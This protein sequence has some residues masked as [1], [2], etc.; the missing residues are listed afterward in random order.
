M[1]NH[2]TSRPQ[3]SAFAG[4][5]YAFPLDLASS[6]GDP[7]HAA[8]EPFNPSSAMDWTP[9]SSYHQDDLELDTLGPA[10]SGRGVGRL[11]AHFE[12]KGFV[13]FENKAYAPPLPPRPQPV[14]RA[15]FEGLPYFG[16]GPGLAPSF[17]PT[18]APTPAQSPA[19]EPQWGNFGLQSRLTSPVAASCFAGL[20]HDP[21]GAAPGPGQLT[22]QFG[23]LDHFVS[24][25]RAQAP[26]RPPLS[27]AQAVPSPML[28]PPPVVTPSP[29]T[30]GTPGFA[31]WRPPASASVKS[32]AP[33]PTP[34]TLP[35]ASY[36]KPPLPNT[37]KPNLGA[38]GS[39]FILELN[40]RAKARGKTPAKPPRLRALPS[41]S[42]VPPFSPEIKQEPST[43]HASQLSPSIPALPVSGASCLP[44]CGPSYSPQQAQRQ[45][46]ASLRAHV[47]GTRPSREQV[48]A[49]AWEQ[50]KSTIRAL[51]LDERRPL[52]EVMSV[53]AEKYNFQAT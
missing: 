34:S 49:E 23:V 21:R 5:P 14:P 12:N 52:K 11:V 30:S 43:P 31:I 51:Y 25:S 17:E 50:F 2:P 37:P 46:S 32:E 44:S 36:G 22:P 4:D 38:P 29:P 16:D 1:F 26:T 15:Q 28:S 10:Q 41:S 53:M 18:R 45:A 19:G 8:L 35:A 7:H 40:P 20:Q 3:T 24:G 39:Q 47:A 48:P 27:S 13:P 9:A 6:S 42:A 33:Q